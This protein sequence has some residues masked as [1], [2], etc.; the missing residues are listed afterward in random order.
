MISQQ[1]GRIGLTQEPPRDRAQ[2]TVQWSFQPGEPIVP[3]YVAW[4]CLGRGER[5]ETWLSWS[6]VRTA[7]AV[8]KLLGPSDVTKPRSISALTREAGL[9]TKLSH[10]F[11]PRLYEDGT[12]TDHPH[13]VLEYVE[14]PTLGNVLESEG[15]FSPTDATTIGLQIL[16]ALDYLHRSGLAHLDVKPDNVIFR[17]GRIVLI[18][19]GLVRPIGSPAPSG[20]VWGTEAYMAPEQASRKPATA[21]ADIY[22]LGATLAELVTNR[23]PPLPG[24]EL[25]WRPASGAGKRLAT[26]IEALLHTDPDRRPRCARSAM[27]AL[28]TIRPTIEPPWPAFVDLTSP[29]PSA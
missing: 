21:A 25:R 15:P 2:G 4:T 23:R 5:C 6:L 12:S 17:D 8:V 22:G 3:G 28:R 29:P 27:V 16:M 9:L 7:P 10:P 20:P 26:V 14:G 24:S 11:L 19:L 18:D 1:T 13:V